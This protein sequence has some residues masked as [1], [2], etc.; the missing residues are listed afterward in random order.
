MLTI[1]VGVMVKLPIPVFTA[2]LNSLTGV[3][4]EDPAGTVSGYVTLLVGLVQVLPELQATVG[5]ALMMEAEVDSECVPVVNV[6]DVIVIFQPAPEPL[7][8]ITVSASE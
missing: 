5:I 4:A 7:A 1:I 2:A 3:G 6:V 8:S